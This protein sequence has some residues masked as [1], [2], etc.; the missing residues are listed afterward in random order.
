[1]A[2]ERAMKFQELRLGTKLGLGFAALLLLVL[3]L[4]TMGIWR[5]E[6]IAGLTE[7][8]VRVDAQ[9]ERI[10]RQWLAETRANAVRAVV[11][12]RTSDAETERLLKPEIEAASGRSKPVATKG[13]PAARPAAS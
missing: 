1:M 13:A 10:L 3:A 12:S 4:A 7:R 8:V 11:V 6:G 9:Q 2:R 5:L